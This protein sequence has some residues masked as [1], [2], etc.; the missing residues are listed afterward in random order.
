MSAYRDTLASYDP[1]V[2]R[3]QRERELARMPTAP[4]T[5][6]RRVREALNPPVLSRRKKAI[7]WIGTPLIAVV[8]CA[9]GYLCMGAFS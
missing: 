7:D 6:P 2:A 5:L 1:V 4:L 8:I 9:F 3:H